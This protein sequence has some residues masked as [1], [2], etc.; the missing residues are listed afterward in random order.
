M[1]AQSSTPVSIDFRDLM[2]AFEFASAG[3]PREHRAHIC[4]NTGKS[5][6]SSDATD[7]EEALPDDL[8]TSDAHIS[9][10][11]KNG[12]DLGRELVA[13]FV[14][15]ELPEK[16]DAVRDMFRKRGAFGRSKDLLHSH[17]ARKK[18]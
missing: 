3:L 9:V 8:E 1:Q 7:A 15:Q 6:F 5:I 11:H 14:R 17:G 4:A 2:F 12:L 13:S 10:P 16:W 18:W